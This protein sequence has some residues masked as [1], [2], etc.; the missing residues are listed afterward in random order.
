MGQAMVAASTRA[1]PIWI[2][3][4][5]LVMGVAVA[6]TSAIL[7]R[8]ATDA[9]ALAI[10]FWRCAA[11]AAV[12][13]PFAWRR[14]RIG[15]RRLVVPCIAGAFL[16]VHFATWISS[17]GLTTIAASVL[18]VSTSPV[19]VA[20]AA[21]TVFRE[22]LAAPGWVGI[23]LGLAGTAVIVGLE[24]RGSSVDGNLLALAGGAAGGGYL[25]AG[26]VARR[27]LGIMQYAVTTYGVAALLLLVVCLAGGVELASYDPGTWWALVGIVVGPQLIGHTTI[28]FVLKEI[29]STSVSATV[30]A[31]PV[32][33]V[34]LAYLL[35]SEVPPGGIYGGGAAILAGIYLVSRARRE[36]ALISE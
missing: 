32:I 10:S 5:L 2:A 8:Y 18:L 24:L 35:F 6:S 19:F 29:D 12:L 36:P 1:R 21:R 27:E 23:G 34:V 30:M 22:R 17:L 11:G 33:A 20:L 9:P 3:W 7:V 26:Q 4:T 25:M 13:A 16:A 15:A 14:G 28:N 31:E